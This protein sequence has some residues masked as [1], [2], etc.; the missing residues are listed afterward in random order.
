M[1]I[2]S[3]ALGCGHYVTAVSFST[4]AAGGREA[5]PASRISDTTENVRHLQQPVA[6]K[7]RTYFPLV[8][9][10]NNNHLQGDL[11]FRIL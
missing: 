6:F 7:A 10:V 9:K 4:I 11:N 2:W 5:Q 1:D 3:S 8:G